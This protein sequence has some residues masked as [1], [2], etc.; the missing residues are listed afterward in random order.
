MAGMASVVGC[1]VSYTSLTIAVVQLECHVIAKL[2]LLAMIII[3]SYCVVT[4]F[5]QRYCHLRHGGFIEQNYGAQ[6]L[7]NVD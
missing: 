4:L 7:I 6:K 3:Q 5:P 1:H 2:N